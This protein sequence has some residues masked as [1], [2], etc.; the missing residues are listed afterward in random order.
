MLTLDS[1]VD[2][3]AVLCAEILQVYF[4]LKLCAPREESQPSN[5]YAL[6]VCTGYLIEVYSVPAQ[7][8]NRL[9][10]FFVLVIFDYFLAIG[11]LWDQHTRIGTVANCRLC[12]AACCSV[13]AAALY[14]L[15]TDKLLAL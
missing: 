8:Y 12:Y 9:M 1:P 4:L 7:S 15:W 13:C 3:F 5:V 11:H 10:I 2:F 6:L 14:A